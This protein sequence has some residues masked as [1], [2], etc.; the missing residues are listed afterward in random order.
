MKLVSV[1]IKK[2]DERTK[3][4]AIMLGIYICEGHIG[5]YED[6]SLEKPR[7]PETNQP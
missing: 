6:R 1:L 4:P 5:F 7:P 2:I 3:H